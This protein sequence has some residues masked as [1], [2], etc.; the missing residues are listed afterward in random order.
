MN[1]KKESVDEKQDFPRSADKFLK[2][3]ERKITLDS[4]HFS[5]HTHLHYFVHFLLCKLNIKKA[6]CKWSPREIL[7]PSV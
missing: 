3:A 2:K 6:N 4:H 7:I 1:W 5:H